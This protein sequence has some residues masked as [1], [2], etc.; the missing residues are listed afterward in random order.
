[1]AKNQETKNQ[2]QSSPK[3][4]I[5]KKP[6]MK[7]HRIILINQSLIAPRNSTKNPCHWVQPSNKF[8][9]QVQEFQRFRRK[10]S[11]I[12]KWKIFS[13]EVAVMSNKNSMMSWMIKK[14]VKANPYFHKKRKWSREFFWL[15]KNCMI[16]WWNMDAKNKSYQKAVNRSKN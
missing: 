9:M 6:L 11:I 2:Y 3:M 7:V 15:K 16:F 1:M 12:K 4:P 5:N 13:R 10:L 8:G 14:Y